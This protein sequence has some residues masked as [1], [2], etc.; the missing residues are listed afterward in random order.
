MDTFF[1]G[2][3]SDERSRKV[4]LIDLTGQKYGRLTVLQIGASKPRSNGKPRVSWLCLCECGNVVDVQSDAL[5]TGNTK[6]CGCLNLDNLKQRSTTHGHATR[7]NRTSEYEA[8]EGMKKRCGKDPDYL[9]IK[10]CDEWRRSF[11]AFLRDMGPKPTA[12]HSL[13]RIDPTGDYEPSNCRWIPMSAQAANKRKTLWVE[14]CGRKVSAGVL[15]KELGIHRSSLYRVMNRGV[16]IEDAVCHLKP[17]A[18]ASIS[19]GCD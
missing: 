10:V 2:G 7:K 17:S 14:W 6:S 1:G 18:M 4:K 15:A 5:R 12:T 13:D 11:E 16:T 9:D 8:W 19:S 3:V